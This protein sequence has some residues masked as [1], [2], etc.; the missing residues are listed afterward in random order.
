M[1][2]ICRGILIGGKLRRRERGGRE[3]CVLPEESVGEGEI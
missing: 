1:R 3:E 2:E